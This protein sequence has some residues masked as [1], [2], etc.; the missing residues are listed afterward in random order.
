VI[1]CSFR[2]LPPSGFPQSPGPEAHRFW[3]EVP[4]CVTPARDGPIWAN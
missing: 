3:I 4:R 2:I 1:V